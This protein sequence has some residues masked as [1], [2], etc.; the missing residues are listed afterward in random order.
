MENTPLSVSDFVALTNQTLE[1]AYPTVSLEGEVAEFKVS[2]GK[3]VYFKLKDNSSSVDCFMSLSNLRVPISDGMKAIIIAAPKLTPWGRFSLT[4]RTIR[5]MGEGSIKKSFEILKAKLND[6]GLF[7]DVR[8]R[9]L[10]SIPQR[11]TVISSTEAA[12]YTDFIKILNQRWGGLD[13]EVLH[14]QVQGEVAPD[15]IIGALK[16]ANEA[17]ELSDVIVIVRGGGGAD[18]LSV[19]NDE[20]LVR[21]IAASRIPTLVGVGHERDVSLA[22]L[23][24]DVRAATPSNAAEIL[25]PDRREVIKGAHQQATSLRYLLI[26]AVDNYSERTHDNLEAIFRR[27]QEKLDDTFEHL[28]TMRV[29]VAQLNPD[30]VLKRGYALLRGEQKV[31]GIIEVET[32]QTIMKAEVQDVRSK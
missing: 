25:V 5:P 12:G 1:Y 6:E 13:I 30:N 11:V 8:K 18:E 4:I 2:Q 3:W 10:P 9:R 15:Q 26:Q 22:D 29:V 23:A 27:I 24:A 28:A 32:L 19:F 16:Y 7:D 31:G 21:A 14:V 17:E 20:A